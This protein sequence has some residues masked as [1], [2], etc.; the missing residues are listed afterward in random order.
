MKASQVLEYYSQEKIQEAL[1]ELSKNRE[2]VGVFKNGAY[3]TRPNTLVY[4]EDITAMVKL[5]VIEFHSSLERWNNPMNLK[6]DNYESLR[7]GWDLVLDL[8][9]EYKHLDHGKIFAKSFI[10]GLKKHGIKNFSLKFTGSTGFHII[11]PWEAIPNEINYEK[12]VK[13]FPELPR[14]IAEYLISYIDDKVQKEFFKKYSAEELAEQ[15]NKPLGKILSTEGLNTREIAKDFITTDS[16]LLSPRHL[17]RMPYSL[18]S[19]T[20]LVSLPLEEKNLEAFQK[21]DAEPF[22]IKPKGSFLKEPEPD[23]AGVLIAEALDWHAKEGDKQK[24]KTP[25]QRFKFAKR[26]DEDMFPPCMKNILNGLSDGKKRSLFILI[27]ALK[28]MKWSSSEIEDFINKWNQKNT[29]SLKENYI[30]GQLRWHK[31]RNI[32]PPACTKEGYY[33][34]IGVCTPDKIC[35][36][37]KKTVKNPVNY[38]WRILGKR[39]RKGK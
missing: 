32:L 27:N 19:K 24:L 1:I 3:D 21:R 28:A 39:K 37:N 18:H 14:A 35:G 17:F 29:P 13:R 5:G 36:G 22:N 31:N 23:E 30:R 38:P 20:F 9:L 34:D 7:T 11:I 6:A 15:T 10:W 4:P 33:I 26:I 8:D 16:V 2:V 25:K 12:T